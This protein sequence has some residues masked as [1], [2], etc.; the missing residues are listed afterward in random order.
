MDVNQAMIQVFRAEIMTNALY[1]SYIF[2][3]LKWMICLT[4][5]LK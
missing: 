5:A 2:A 3:V 4:S 1:T